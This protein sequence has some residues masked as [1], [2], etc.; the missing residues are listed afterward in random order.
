MFGDKGI[1]EYGGRQKIENRNENR[2]S[3]NRASELGHIVTH[4]SIG[5]EEET[6]GAREEEGR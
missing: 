6:S 1:R 4:I 2:A 3:E 5:L